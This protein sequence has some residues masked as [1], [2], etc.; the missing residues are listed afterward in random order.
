MN[1]DDWIAKLQQIYEANKVYQQAKEQRQLTPSPKDTADTFMKQSRAHDLMRQIQ[2][3]LLNGEGI[4]R[5]YEDVGGY[6]RAIV[7][8]WK[9]PV[10]AASKPANLKD[11]DVSIIIGANDK[12]IFVNDKKLAKPTP[13]AL[14]Q[15][16]LDLAQGFIRK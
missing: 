16:L 11:V 1:D 10:S 6:N 12:G 15:A 5:F 4:L 8:M 13:E 3:V 9:G 2:K 14:K 7:L